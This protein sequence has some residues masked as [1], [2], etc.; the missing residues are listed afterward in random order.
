MRSEKKEKAADKLIKAGTSLFAEKGYHETSVRDI[1]KTA[2]V[3]PSLINYHFGGKEELY[4]TILEEAGITSATRF[5]RI[6]G[7]VASKE[8]FQ[9]R[10]KMMIEEL[11]KGS[12]HNFDIQRIIEQVIHNQNDIGEEVFKERHF[13]ILQKI[14]DF[15]NDAQNKGFIRSDIEPKLVGLMIVAFVR[16]L[17]LMRHAINNFMGL[18]IAEDSVQ[19]QTIDTLL[20]LVLAGLDKDP[21]RRSTD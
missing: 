20:K 7:E 3:N 1:A 4:R 8:E 11:V 9:F 16:N 14:I 12:I 21:G 10:F 13:S 5:H 18:N 2:G 6:L 17:S 19:N 15:I